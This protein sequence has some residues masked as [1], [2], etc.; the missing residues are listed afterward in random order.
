MSRECNVPLPWPQLAARPEACP[1]ACPRGVPRGRA[2][3]NMC[4]AAGERED[5]SHI[6]VVGVRARLGRRW[7][8]L[9]ST[10]LR[11]PLLNASR[12]HILT[13]KARQALRDVYDVEIILVRFLNIRVL[14]GNGNSRVIT[15][16]KAVLYYRGGRQF[17]LC[18]LN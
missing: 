1:A 7:R 9:T 11:E 5:L 13:E 8:S 15:F 18:K 3:F 16:R 4:Y 14:E 2:S 10:P 12:E 17:S 6:V